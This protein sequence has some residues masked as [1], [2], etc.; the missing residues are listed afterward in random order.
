MIEC[1]AQ[2]VEASPG[3]DGSTNALLRGEHGP[4]QGAT[5]WENCIRCRFNRGFDD[6]KFTIQCGYGLKVVELLSIPI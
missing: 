1:P 3:W 5:S 4:A 2:K 6:E